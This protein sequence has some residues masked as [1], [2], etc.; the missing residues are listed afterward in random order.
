M[1]L[2][3][4]T[5]GVL[6]RVQ[7]RGGSWRIVCVLEV[8][9]LDSFVADCAAEIFRKNRVTRHIVEPHAFVGVNHKDSLKEITQVSKGFLIDPVL[10]IPSL[11]PQIKALQ[12]FPIDLGLFI[13]ERP[14]RTLTKQHKI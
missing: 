1:F 11:L 4:E 7:F 3:P 6:V 8:A 14:E 10:L 13:F 5:V 12:A 2:F 9:R